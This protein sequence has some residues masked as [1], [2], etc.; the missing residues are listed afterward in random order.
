MA[1]G[2]RFMTPS[3]TEPQGRSRR[4]AMTSERV[5]VK[6]MLR[7]PTAEEAARPAPEANVRL[8]V[9]FFRGVMVSSGK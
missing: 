7:V 9:K 4:T 6:S 3:P 2:E 5:L 1:R 8:A